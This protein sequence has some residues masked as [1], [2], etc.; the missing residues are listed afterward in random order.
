MLPLGAFLFL[1]QVIAK[2]FRDVLIL[3]SGQEEA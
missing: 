2:L 3:I 1:L